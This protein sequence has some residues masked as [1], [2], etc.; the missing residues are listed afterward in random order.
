MNSNFLEF[1]DNVDAVDLKKPQDVRGE[2]KIVL[3]HQTS[4]D[5][6]IYCS[7]I[8]LHK[9]YLYSNLFHLF[10]CFGDGTDLYSTSGHSRCKLV[11]KYSWNAL[12][13]WQKL[14]SI[15]GLRD[16]EYRSCSLLVCDRTAIII[17]WNLDFIFR[18]TTIK[19]LYRF[20]WI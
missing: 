18:Y 19:Q 4:Y 11:V 14:K 16:V 1:N 3:K 12:Q 8:F 15:N 7:N 6:F 20:K 5:K 13:R 2:T 9:M 17:F 10:L